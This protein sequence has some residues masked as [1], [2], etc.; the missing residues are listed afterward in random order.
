MQTPAKPLGPHEIVC[1]GDDCTFLPEF[2]QE[3][4]FHELVVNVP[5]NPFKD[6]YSI[7]MPLPPEHTV[8]Y[9]DDGFWVCPRTA[10]ELEE[11]ADLRRR[12][13]AKQHPLLT[14]LLHFAAR[15][16]FGRSAG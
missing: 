5:Y 7:N 6:N 4:L 11:I 16:L 12:N 2:F 3:A 13:R 14:S 8:R 9:C 1:G 10:A 15:R